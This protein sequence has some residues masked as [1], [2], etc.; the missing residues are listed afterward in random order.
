MS[1]MWNWLPMLN[2]IFHNWTATIYTEWEVRNSS[3]NLVIEK[4]ILHEN[5]PVQIC[6]YEGS[7]YITCGI[8]KNQEKEITIK[9]SP[10]YALPTWKNRVDLIVELEDCLWEVGKFEST[11]YGCSRLPIGGI[12][13]YTINLSYNG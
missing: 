13:A 10:D 12:Y 3:G 6:C 7:S 9:I 2:N 1:W 11:H 5:I 4:T 8:V